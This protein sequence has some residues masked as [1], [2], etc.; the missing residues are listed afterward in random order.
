VQSRVDRQIRALALAKQC[1]AHGARVRTISH[2]SG[3]NPRDVLR[4]LFPDR[5][6]VP[7]GRSPD[8]PE[9]YHGANLLYQA[10]AS[11]VISIYRRLRTA[12]IGCSEALLGAYRHYVGLCKAPHRI[13]F[14]RAF[15]LA[16]HTDGLWLTE[17]RSF[18][19]VVC[20]ACHSEFLAAFGSVALSN[21]DCPFCKL[22]QRYGTDPRVQSSFPVQ[23]LAI[24]SAMQL[25]MLILLRGTGLETTAHPHD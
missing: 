15:D 18:S 8:S 5:L 11:I 13:S 1:A 10:E 22:V 24:P 25:G 21:D 20:P 17:S 6:A 7:R 3:L 9:W 12:D 19:L 4:L 16:A 23:P 14:D 2:L